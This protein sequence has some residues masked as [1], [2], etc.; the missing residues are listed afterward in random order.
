MIAFDTDV[1]IY[2]VSHNHPLGIKIRQLLADPSLDQN[3]TGSLILYPELLSKPIREGN[4]TQLN[5]L[6]A[7]LNK[8]TLYPMDKPIASLAAQLAASYRLKAADAIH[9]ATAV[10]IGADRF[11]TNNRRDFDEQRIVEITV[12]YPDSL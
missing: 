12:Q 5:I 7:Y 8:L 10:H 6:A 9:L 3:R 4:Q 1:L 2:A 11:I